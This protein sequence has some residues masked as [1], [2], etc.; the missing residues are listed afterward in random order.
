MIF[1][2]VCK[3]L[4]VTIAWMLICFSAII[5]MQLFLKENFLWKY[6]P[7]EM[8]LICLH[9]MELLKKIMTFYMLYIPL[10]FLS[11]YQFLFSYALE[12]ISAFWNPGWNNTNKRMRLSSGVTCWQS[13]RSRF[14][15]FY[16][17]NKNY[18]LLSKH[19]H[20][21]SRKIAEKPFYEAK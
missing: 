16:V 9:Q 2:I 10:E 5:L 8:K 13:W 6:I 4:L 12:K 19:L 14:S 17:T 7:G 11:S 1:Y 20:I 21:C 15:I 18:F 3:R